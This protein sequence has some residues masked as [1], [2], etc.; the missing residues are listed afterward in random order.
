MN[1]LHRKLAPISEGAW[2]QIEEEAVR[3]LKRLSCPKI[4]LH[5]KV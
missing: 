3:T 5:K 1:N 2:A 4:A